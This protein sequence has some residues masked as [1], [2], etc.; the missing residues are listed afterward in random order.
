MNSILH[1]GAGKCGS[2]SLQAALSR[3]PVFQSK[4]RKVNYEYLSLFPAICDKIIRKDMVFENALRSPQGYICSATA[5]NISQN[6]NY[7]DSIRHE[8][9]QVLLESIIPILSFE[10]WVAE[11]ATFTERKI[12]P[13]LGLKPK[14]V[15]FIRPQIAW[16]N[17]AWW[18][19]GAWSGRSFKDWLADSA[20]N[21]FHWTGYIQQWRQIPGV[22]SVEVHSASRDVV[23][24]FYR[25]LGASPPEAEKANISLDSDVLRFLQR[26]RD[27]RDDP[28]DPAND[29]IL[30]RC[31][32]AD[33]GGA[34]WVIPHET[35]A[36]L[37]AYYRESNKQLL[38][39]VPDDERRIIESDP[40]WWDAEAYRN[41][42]VEPAEAPA[43]T[44]EEMENLT[45][46]AIQAVIRLDGEM[47]AQ[48]PLNEHQRGQILAPQ[49]GLPRTLRKAVSING[50]RRLL[51][52]KQIP[53]Q[54]KRR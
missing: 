34:P 10:G 37:I 6:D 7:I 38:S 36:E 33:L 40:H 8:I 19:W 45:R 11:G 16:L 4:D 21:P 48:L 51:G 39:L 5:G 28:D 46:R 15:L 1:I 27:F 53:G 44:I 50:M 23:K 13:R 25:S 17:S 42:E 54:M 32:P 30:E 47:R 31:L 12:L 49:R 26:H 29:F 20:K 22:E 9:S 43:P 24:T 18:Q 52:M 41:R 14:V 35:T 2:S 3:N